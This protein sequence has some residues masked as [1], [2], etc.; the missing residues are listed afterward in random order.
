MTLME[1]GGGGTT[2]EE[3]KIRITQIGMNDDRKERGGR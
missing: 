2:D 1:E 3:E